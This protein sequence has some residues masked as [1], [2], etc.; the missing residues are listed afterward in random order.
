MTRDMRRA[1]S[2]FVPSCSTGAVFGSA[3][4]HLQTWLQSPAD[5]KASGREW[6]TAPL[7]GVGLLRTVNGHGDLLHDGRAR[8]VTEAILWHGG[9]AE[10]ARE[11]FRAMP[12]TDREALVKFVESL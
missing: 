4:S 9:Q 10:K 8:G 2:T 1:E 11:A 3:S 6:R 12:R 5:F 7:W